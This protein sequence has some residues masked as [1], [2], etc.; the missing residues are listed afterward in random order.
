MAIAQFESGPARRDAWLDPKG[1]APQLEAQNRFNR[2]A[3][4]PT[5]RT[6]VPR[7]TAA[8]RVWR[9]AIHV[10][11]HHVRLNFIVLHLLSRRGM[12]DGVDEVPQFHGAVAAAL[13]RRRQG[14]P[15]GGVCV[16]AAVLADARHV[17]FD[18]ARLKGAFIERRVEQ[19]DQLVAG[20]HQTLLNRVH[21]R[22]SPR[23]VRCT[24]NDRPRLW[25]RVDLALLV[26]G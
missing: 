18:V 2:D 11:G 16:L 20:A 24:R 7:P 1:A 5:R 15:R 14:N 25:D 22:L 8:P 17:S 19:L 23:R 4:Q 3:V 21:R 26:L 10:G 6:G 13:Q 12:V 9:G